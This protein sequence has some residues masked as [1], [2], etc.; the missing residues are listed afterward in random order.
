VARSIATIEGTALVPGVS[1]NGRL[2]SKEAIAKA[3]ARLTERIAVG[4]DPAVMLTSHCADDD[5]RRIVGRLTSVALAEDGSARFA[6]QLADTDEGRKIAALVD[7]RGGPAF[8]KGVS[9]RG[10]W[11]SKVRREPGPDGTPVETADDLEIS[12]LDFTRKPGVPGAEIDTFTPTSSS[13]PLE[14]DPDGRVLITESVDEATV[15]ITETDSTDDGP[16][17]DP[18]YRTDKQ[19]RYVLAS[20]VQAKAAWS[21]IGESETARLYT[22]AQ[23]KRVKGRIVKALKGYGVT[24]AA[25]EGWLIDPAAAVNESLAE[26]W[27]MASPGG[28]LY[29]SLTNGPTTVSVTSRL[30]D[31]HDLDAVGRAAMAGACDA[32]MALDPDMDADIDVPGVEP[33]DTDDDMG[34]DEPG[35]ACP[36]GCGC[37]VPHQMAVGAGCPCACGC[38][39]CQAPGGGAAESIP[40]AI[41]G[42]PLPPEQMAALNAVGFFE[43]L[44]PG[45]VITAAMVNEAIAP[46]TP[47]PETAAE[48]P[49]QETE[50]AM[51]ESITPAPETPG[52]TTSLDDLGAKLDGLTSA[53]TGF[54]TAMS[55]KPV[56]AAP[57]APTPVVE[58]APVV[59]ETQEQMIDRLVA[60][61]IAKRL[62]AAVQETVEQSGPPTRKGL[63]TGVTENAAPAG[64]APG[65]NEYG[66]PSN[67]P[68]KPLHEYNA[69]ERLRYFGPAV[70][71]HV[72]QDRFLG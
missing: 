25:Q 11:A 10:A 45:A 24:V 41:A 44:E 4:T 3:V 6:A 36:C 57:A 1:K 20:K 51:A 54:V 23:L 38:E 47:A 67:W 42:Q 50:P 12:G 14:T 66:V 18:G 68:N 16:F 49:T 29:I 31:P 22:S 43:R 70:R 46:Q 5:S 53:L 65:L 55:N 28:D 19:K 37:A 59:E 39:V 62:P 40:L 27:D 72:L 32:L 52:P 33:E 64:A 30:L 15:T 7:T 60:E 48:T 56:E 21:A 35:S 17:A 2:Y 58:A 26:C 9:I 69:D 61:G 63:V 34:D 8:L 13:L 71:E